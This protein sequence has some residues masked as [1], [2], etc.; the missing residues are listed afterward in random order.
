MTVNVSYAIANVFNSTANAYQAT[1]VTVYFNTTVQSGSGNVLVNSGSTSVV[2]Y[3]TS[4]LSTLGDPTFSNYVLKDYANNY[5][6]RISTIHSD[7]SATLVAPAAAGITSNVNPTNFKYQVVNHVPITYDATTYRFTGDSHQGNGT[8][9]TSNVSNTITGTST[10]FTKQFDIGYQIFANTYAVDGKYE[11]LLGVVKRVYSNT[12]AEF[13]TVSGYTLT[14]TAYRFFDPVTP[15][16]PNLTTQS[17]MVINNALLQWSR[18]GLIPG[19]TQ[20]KSY[21]P[22]VQDPETGILVNFPA[23]MHTS[24]SG[25]RRISGNRMSPI[26]KL[27]HT[28]IINGTGEVHD[29]DADNPILGSSIQK[30]IDSIPMNNYIK[31]LAASNAITD[32][33]YLSSL[34]AGI[35]AVYGKSIIPPA[36]GLV[37]YANAIPTGF[38]KMLTANVVDTLYIP[39]QGPGANVIYVLNESFHSLTYPTAA[40]QLAIVGGGQP[41]PRVV[42]NRSDANVYYNVTNPINTLLDADKADL[43][44][45]ASNQ[46]STNDRKA[47][48]VT[49]VP[50]A[51]P[52]LMNVVLMDENPAN[53][54]YRVPS[55]DP[56]IINSYSKYNPDIPISILNPLP[57]I[58]SVPGSGSKT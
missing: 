30:A 6:G 21:H 39:Y 54:L 58:N 15:N 9:T 27:D 36:P 18:S 3:G 41:I 51:I 22:P 42:N 11:S 13:T 31:K 10:I 2:G 23:T 4:F 14:N 26:D 7:T 24:V 16:A 46:F 5:I 53:R 19:I 49:G 1:P 37:V 56:A 8:I 55:Y 44:A 45:R 50:A 28:N 29:F 43:A 47:V 17:S 32:S 12:S 20:V 52:G 25:G 35:Q 34:T 48:K 38:T 33:N 57:P 40:D